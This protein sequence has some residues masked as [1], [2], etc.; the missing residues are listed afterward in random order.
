MENGKRPS[1]IECVGDVPW[2]THLCQFYES[3][4]DLVDVLT[5]Y[6]RAG[7]ESNEFCI[8][9]T[10]EPLT[11]EMAEAAAR[12][13]IP[14]FDRYLQKGQIEILSYDDWYL[15][16][17]IFDAQRVL[18]GWVEKLNRALAKGYAGLRL[19]GNTLWLDRALWE[20]FVHYEEQIDGVISN[21]PV[22]ALCSYSLQRCSGSDVLD[23]L[24]NH[25]YALIRRRGDWE[26]VESSELKRTKDAL[27][28][29]EA[30]FRRLAEN[31]PDIV[32]RYELRSNP[33]LSYVSPAVTDVLGYDPSELYASPGAFL[34][35]VA[36]RDRAAFRELL[37]GPL[38]SEPATVS[39]RHRNGAQKWLELRVVPV[40]D[41]SGRLVAVEGIARDVTERRQ[42]DERQR[43]IVEASSTLASSLDYRTTVASIAQ[44][45]VPRMADLCTLDLLDEAGSIQLA[46]TA[47]RDREKAGWARELRGRFPVDPG[48][49]VGVPRVI[50]TGQPELYPEISDSLLESL[51]KDGEEL[52]ALRD[53]GY[54]SAMVVPLQAHGRI[55]GAMTLV[56]SESGRTYGQT[57]LQLAEELARRAAVALDNARLYR[58]RER[59]G[60]E[61]RET[62]DYLEKLVNYANAPIIVWDPAFKITR[63]NRAFERLTGYLAGEVLGRDLAVLF[64][65]ASRDES[66]REITRTLTGEYWE[67][68]EI[69]ILRKDGDTRIALWNSANIYAEDG[70][71]LLATIAQ[72]QDITE[73]KL[74][75]EELR[76]LSRA[77]E[78]SPATVVIT[79]TEGNIEY[80]NPKFQETTGY[81]TEE[82]LGK[83]PR[84]LKSGHTTQ[85]E[86]RRLW[87]TIKDGGE[88]RGEFL[89]KKKNGDL[90]WESASI[91][92]IRDASGT[93]THFLAVKEDIT[94]RKRTEEEIRKLNADLTR[95]AQE[96]D[97]IN[98]ELESFSY[99][100]SHDLRAPLRGIDGFSQA[101]LE[102]YGDRLDDQGREYLGRVRAGTQR[103]AQL[104]DD[105]LSLSRV[106]RSEMVWEEVDL[107]ALAQD[108][109]TDLARTEPERQVE[110]AIEPQVVVRGD[111]RLL[112]SVL[113]NL[114]GNAWKFTSKHPTARI[115][116]GTTLQDGERVY[117]VRDDGAGFDMEY[118][119]KLF[120]TFQ[121]LHS[122]A[123]FPGT[124]IGLA[125]VQRIVRRH[126]GRVWA[127]GAPEQGATVYF[128]LGTRRDG[129]SGRG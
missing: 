56:S 64:P 99:S 24:R 46:A 31:A 54:R 117:F 78:Q 49:P 126:G 35:F 15:Q 103:M 5:S 55:L 57:D 100:V 111:P 52:R 11:A 83:N 98:K 8:W 63:F 75:E 47:H 71:T 38:A 58:D 19:T 36:L 119:G 18:G 76:K 115:E 6:F 13:A 90:Y 20:D 68:V 109:A 43:F 41:E 27:Q 108:A 114:I 89:N 16:G 28:E 61:L 60:Q 7:L 87:K 101:L 122:Q 72:G 14:G 48:S 121:R 26:L 127:E 80:A 3:K 12:E 91:S 123:E 45:T 92:P 106:T 33:G 70:T 124:G 21:L 22:I 97:A 95:R 25:R 113:E 59:T 30:H 120:G 1:G 74:A 88:W 2:G 67:S 104:I 96:L 65:E 93:I 66:L 39:C 86:Y 44:L 51:A 116:F 62:R 118:A 82:A 42:N 105:M 94:E 81:T 50:R 10:S 129:E 77:V 73:R 125:T 79:D 107:S 53:A 84:I 17:G 128:T 23:V 32:F 112:G 85:E 34:G 110:F 9:I 29:S 40:H 37:D 102:E 69:P 4:Q